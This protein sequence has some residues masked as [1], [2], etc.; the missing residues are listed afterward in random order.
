MS[1]PDLDNHLPEAPAERKTRGPLRWLLYAVGL[2]LLG[3][4]IYF[5]IEGTRDGT[6]QSGF[7][8]LAEADPLDIAAI[9][10]LVL[11]QIVLN[12]IAFC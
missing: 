8:K 9:A 5:A 11:V 6:G 10:A 7:A 4:C 2:A 12:G 3:W 1:E